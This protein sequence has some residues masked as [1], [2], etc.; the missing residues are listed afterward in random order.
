M[1]VKRLVQDGAVIATARKLNTE[2]V[3]PIL[4]FRAKPCWRVCSGEGRGTLGS[5]QLRSLV[6]LVNELLHVVGYVRT[7]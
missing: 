4:V 2:A 5:R 3:E 6:C 1:S 7:L